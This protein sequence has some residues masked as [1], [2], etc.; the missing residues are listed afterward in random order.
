MKSILVT[1]GGLRSL[2][3]C[4]IPILEI[5]ELAETIKLQHY[6]NRP[7]T[8]KYP[9]DMRRLA[10]TQSL[11]YTNFGNQRT[12][13]DHKN[14]TLLQSARKLKSILATWGG[15]L[16]LRVWYIPIL[17]IRELAETIKLQYCYNRPENCNV[18]WWHEEACC[19][20]ESSEWLQD[21]TGMKSSLGIK[22]FILNN[23]SRI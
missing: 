13:R 23:H 4:Y 11:V 6:Y 2:R 3:V 12:S 1:W 20:S 18:S 14:S 9:S 22:V 17:E 5:R 8:V 10:V 16:S 19:H 15:L 7:E 21:T